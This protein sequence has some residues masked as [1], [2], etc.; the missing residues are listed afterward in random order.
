[1]PPE[2]QAVLDARA[3]FGAFTNF[4]L[5]GIAGLGADGRRKPVYVHDKLMLVDDTWATVGSCN[6]HRYSLF[7]NGEMNVS[8]AEPDTVRALRCALLGEHLGHDTAGMDDR[9][10]LELFRRIAKDNRM[11]QD[12]GD[13]AWQGL[14]FELDLANYVG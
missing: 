1:V 11:K 12:A 10:A 4:M 2:R 6:L 13:P 5:A 14:A 9:A 3:R 7:G 8:F